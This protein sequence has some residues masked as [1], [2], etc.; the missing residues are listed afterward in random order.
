LGSAAAFGY[1]YLA[2]KKRYLTVDFIMDFQFLEHPIQSRQATREKSQAVAPV[3]R[4]GILL[5]PPGGAMGGGLVGPDAQGTMK[6]A[7]HR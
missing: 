6:E 5:R 4:A 2:T 3:K 1:E 7:D